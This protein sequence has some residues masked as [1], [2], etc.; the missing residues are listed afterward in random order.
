MRTYSLRTVYAVSNLQ[1]AREVVL[2]QGETQIQLLR[3]RKLPI[4]TYDMMSVSSDGRREVRVSTLYRVHQG[5][6]LLLEIIASCN[7]DDNAIPP[8]VRP[9]LEAQTA[10]AAGLITWSWPGVVGPKLGDGL[11]FRSE[12]EDTWTWFDVDLVRITDCYQSP[13][14]LSA[15]LADTEKRIAKLQPEAQQ[16]AEAALRWWRHSQEVESPADRL[17]SLWIIL[18][19]IAFTLSSTGSIHDRVRRLLKR[20]FPE[21]AAIDNGNLISKMEKVLSDARNRTA[22]GGKRDISE[23]NTTVLVAQTAA[24]ASIML[25]LGGPVTA[26][27]SR[28]LLEQLGIQQ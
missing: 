3:E 4:A 24:E 17:L 20:V 13:A 28:G 27:P 9:N 1:F 2:R 11:F 18:E 21:L 7:T 26:H 6:P 25:L 19:I 23:P 12:A 14:E 5:G 10:R 16:A 22:H 15:A 8:D